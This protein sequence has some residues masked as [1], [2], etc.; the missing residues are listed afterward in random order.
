MTVLATLESPSIYASTAEIE[1]PDEPY[2]FQTVGHLRSVYGADA[3]LFFIM[4]SDSFFEFDTWVSPDRILAES[5]LIVA[6][7]PA[8][9]INRVQQDNIVDLRGL[10][11]DV[12]PSLMARSGRIYLT[13]YVSNEISATGIRRR[14]SEGLSIKGLVPDRVADYIYKYELYKVSA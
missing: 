10:K 7:R 9:S 12:D 1:A 11:R 3:M 8:F 4:G 2:T 13:D 6:A 5:N 14:L